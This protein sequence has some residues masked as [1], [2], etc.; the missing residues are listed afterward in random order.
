MRDPCPASVAMAEIMKAEGLTNAMRP[1]F[2][3]INSGMQIS[4]N[5]M[6]SRN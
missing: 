1:Q 6:V 2:Y 5:Q 3:D 4:D